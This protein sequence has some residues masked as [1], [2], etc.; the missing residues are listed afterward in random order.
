MIGD[1]ESVYLINYSLRSYGER[2]NFNNLTVVSRARESLW[3]RQLQQYPV[4]TQSQTSGIKQHWLLLRSPKIIMFCGQSRTRS[5]VM[6]DLTSVQIWFNSNQNET[7]VLFCLRK[8]SFSRAWTS[9]KKYTFRWLCFYLTRAIGF[10]L[11]QKVHYLRIYR[12]RR[13]ICVKAM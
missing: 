10:R 8:K 2:E 3:Q 1:W 7:Y 4:W 6:E 12:A 13:A 11:S 5:E 9:F